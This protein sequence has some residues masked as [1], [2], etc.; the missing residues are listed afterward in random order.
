MA[1]TGPESE[2]KP[3]QK[4]KTIPEASP[5]HAPGPRV[6]RRWLQP[7]V[8]PDAPAHVRHVRQAHRWRTGGYAGRA[9]RYV[10]PPAH[11]PKR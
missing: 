10:R 8:T 1:G 7:L 3:N 4:S 11:V 6:A 9:S 2:T 5:R